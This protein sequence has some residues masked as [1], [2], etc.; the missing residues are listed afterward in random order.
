MKKY[1][2]LMEDRNGRPVE[3]SV[4]SEEKSEAVKLARGIVSAS[5]EFIN[6]DEGL[7]LVAEEDYR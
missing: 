2:F 4:I 5:R 6:T 1:K 3:L 7:C